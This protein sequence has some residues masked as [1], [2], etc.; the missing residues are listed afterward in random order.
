MVGVPV[1]SIPVDLI[2]LL[3]ELRPATSISTCTSKPSNLDA[4]G[5][6]A[7]R[8]VGRLQRVRAG[9]DP[10]SGDGRTGSRTVIRQA[11]GQAEDAPF[12]VQRIRAALDEGRGVR[13]TARLLKVLPPR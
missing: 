1:G 4:I 12:K 11:L 10:R 3:G 8:D 9:D 6:D 2:G 5:P 7:V 13:E